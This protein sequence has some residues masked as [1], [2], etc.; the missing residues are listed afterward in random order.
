MGETGS[1][2][3]DQGGGTQ[4][5]GPRQGAVPPPS[6]PG[7]WP[8]PPDAPAAAQGPRHPYAPPPHTAGYPPPHAAAYPP[9]HG[10]PPGYAAGYPPPH[11]RYPQPVWRP[12]APLAEWWQR[13]VASLVDGALMFLVQLPGIVL[14]YGW[15]F[16]MWLALM[17]AVVNEQ[18]PPTDLPG[19]SPVA[20][21]GGMA[22]MLLATAA[23]AWYFGWR[24]GLT[25]ETVG[26]RI[27]R[28][29]LVGM[30]DG[31]PIGGKRGLGRYALR[32]VLA[33][34]NVG[35]VSYLWPLWD[36]KRQTWEDM[37]VKSIVVSD[38][39]PA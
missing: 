20:I 22:Y 6:Q 33:A 32:F 34:A 19:W 31:Q 2:E 23:G 4:G 25:G 10:Y 30:Y 14:V 1:F 12:P 7:T 5:A 26:K 37:A 27:M 17:R 28:I 15:F 21:L 18:P 38:D 9:Q 36:A 16:S 11:A 8:R 39:R 35:I 3:P 13:L 24:Q 29:R